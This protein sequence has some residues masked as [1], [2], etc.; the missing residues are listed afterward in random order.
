MTSLP[1]LKKLILLAALVA[2]IFPAPGEGAELAA[3]GGSL[4]SAVNRAFCSIESKWIRL[5]EAEP[6]LQTSIYLPL[7]CKGGYSQAPADDAGW[8]EGDWRMAAANPERTSWTL[9]EV[10][11]KLNPLWYK[12]IEP[13]IPMKVQIVAAFGNLYI[14]TAGGLYVLDADTGAEKWVYATDMPL[15]HSPTVYK[16]VVYVGGLDRKIHAIDAITGRGLWTFEAGRGFNTNPLIVNDVLYAGNRDGY[17]Y[18]VQVEGPEAGKLLWKYQTQGPILF[19][20]AYKDGLVYFA[21]NDSHAYA[22]AAA[23]GKQVWKSDKLPGAGFHSWWP[24]VYRDWV[25]FAG[26]NN[27]RFANDPGPGPIQ[28]L[29]RDEIFPNNQQDP[30]GVM[31]GPVGQEPGDWVAGTPTID[32]SRPNTTEHGSTTPITE[33]FEQKPWRRT[34]FVLDRLTG[35]EYTTDFDKDGK[36]EYAPFLWF[37]SD[38]AG[39]RYP[40]I[41]GSDG[42][43]YMSNNYMSDGAIPGGNI[44]GW[45]IGT[46]HISIALDGWSAIDEPLAYSAGGDLVYRQRCCDRVAAAFDTTVPSTEKFRSWSYFSYDLPDY[47]PGYNIMTH[48][49]E[50]QYFKP[51]GGVYGGRNGS[52][53]WHGD[54]NPPIPYQGKVYFHASNAILAFSPQSGSPNALPLYQKVEPV[55]SA[56]PA[57]DTNALK[58]ILAS[59]VQKMVDAG[60]LRPGY[61]ITGHFDR[62]SRSHCGDYLGDYWHT[63]GDVIVALLRALPHLPPELQAAAR[64]YVRAEFNAF[65]PYEY[66]HIGWRDGAARELFDLPPEVEAERLNF[67]PRKQAQGFEGWRYAPHQ[68]Y[69]LWKYAEEFGGAREIF[70]A[71][72]GNLEQPPSDAVLAEMP[73]VHNAYIAGYMG[74]LELEKLAGYPPSSGIQAELDRLM[75]SRAAGFSIDPPAVYFDDTSKYYCRQINASRNFIYFTPELGY[76]LRDN[77]QAKVAG[78]L[79][80]AA[81]VAPLWFVS[82]M[83]AAFGEDTINNYYDYHALFQ[84]KALILDEP[85]SELI[86]Y[87]DVPAVAVGDLFYIENLVAVIEAKAE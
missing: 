87:L 23:T 58:A 55:P 85:G 46:P 25:I 28:H 44:V 6:D 18:A 67:T 49:W 16:G 2:L 27:Y 10:G 86:R 50:P 39:N 56:P 24:V 69:A 72:K 36:P 57:V 5:V 17:F 30:R 71:A 63:S 9:E 34:V 82:K 42:V 3:L 83:E 41:V 81:R 4:N 15:G 54:V 21:S 43:I 62:R 7:V 14:S 38:G 79:D 26:S 60:H 61:G 74:Y 22:L 45:K 35:E 11:G 70:D 29:E 68:F 76:Y 80:E 75:Q 77:A 53:G 32:T 48:V 19:S 33:Y 64:S 73:H 52:Y 8:G 84:A 47:V 66:A 65:P 31:V 78:V 51:Y 40:P 1:T 12:P 20:A 59:E 13:Y 37:G